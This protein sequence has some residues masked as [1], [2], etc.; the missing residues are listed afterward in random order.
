MDTNS[1][2]W[3]QRV[4]RLGFPDTISGHYCPIAPFSGIRIIRNHGIDDVKEVFPLSL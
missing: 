3:G 1:F 2:C 4:L